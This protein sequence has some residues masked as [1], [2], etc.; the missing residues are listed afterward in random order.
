MSEPLDLVD[1][2]D[3]RRVVL[4]AGCRHRLADEL[5]SLGATSILVIGGGHAADVID[6]LVAG[7]GSLTVE[8]VTGVTQHVPRSEVD[9]A[10]AL[11]DGAGIDTAVAIG[12]GSAVGLA[13]AIALERDVTLVAVPTTYSGS[14]MTDLWG[15]SEGAHKQ[16]GRDP[17][18]RPSVVL[19]DPEL[20]VGLPLPVTA[21]SAF[22]ALGHCVEALWATD[23]TPATTDMATR[24]I[25]VIVGSIRDVAADPTDVAARGRLLHGACL[26]GRVIAEVGTALH[27]RSCHVLG[28]RFGLDHGGM[29][30]VMLPHVV[31][32]NTGWGSWEAV[33]LEA[34]FG[35]RPA[36][37]LD[38]LACAVGAPRSLA[39]LGM[40]EDGLDAELVDEIIVRVGDSNPRPPDPASLRELLERAWR[41]D[42][43]HSAERTSR[44]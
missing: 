20:T 40:P 5:D 36:V 10:V 42:P 33:G 13:K 1:E 29:N 32:Y 30:A 9:A 6:E 39:E 21:A 35:T 11:V 17:R 41:G 22:N 7:L 23:R 19:Y 14:E 12:G 3:G 8:R 2:H 28:G 18:V 43:P 26:A 44:P 16:T 24:G 34:A 25:E 38:E 4:G 31:A 37:G 27:H 15:I